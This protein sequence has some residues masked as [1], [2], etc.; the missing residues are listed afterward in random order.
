MKG[1]GKKKEVEPAR[2]PARHGAGQNPPSKANGAEPQSAP[3]RPVCV[4]NPSVRDGSEAGNSARLSTRFHFSALACQSIKPQATRCP[5]RLLFFAATS[6]C[7]AA[8]RARSAYCTD[9]VH[10][11][12]Q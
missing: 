11:A 10:V 4:C 3:R 2:P 8:A 6:Q 7:P 1:E 9:A 12:G 5:L